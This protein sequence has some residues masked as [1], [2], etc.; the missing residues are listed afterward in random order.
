MTLHRMPLFVWAI[1]TTAFLQVFGTPALAGALLM[2]LLDREF[3]PASST[4]ARAPT[5]WATSTASGFTRTPPST[6]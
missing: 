3:G 1:L 2:E 4:P 5:W 6:S